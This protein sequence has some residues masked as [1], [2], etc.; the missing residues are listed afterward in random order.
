MK[1]YVLIEEDFDIY[2]Y[3]S[4]SKK[5]SPVLKVDKDILFFNNKE[6]ELNGIPIEEWLPV[7]YEKLKH[8]IAGKGKD[9]SNEEVITYLYVY[10][11]KMI[12]KEVFLDENEDYIINYKIDEQ[13]Y[14]KD[15]TQLNLLLN[16]LEKIFH[17]IEPDRSNEKTFSIF[18][19]DLII[20]S[21]TEVETHWK[22]L[23]KLNGY[24]KDNLTTKDYSK[25]MEFINFNFH[26]KLENYP[27]YDEVIPFLNWNIENPTKSLEWYNVYN[28][29]KHDRT[30]SLNNATLYNAIN[31][32]GAVFILVNIRYSNLSTLLNK[33]ELKNEIKTVFKISKSVKVSKWKLYSPYKTLM[34]TKYVKY[35][36]K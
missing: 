12:L 15:I 10:N 26:L 36:E 7:N 21:S 9:G 32:V 27:T 13:T 6:F 17:Y 28:I 11:E 30:N 33:I 35:F 31:S 18:L 34:K 16:D 23:M 8:T 24:K 1:K 22:E 19:R 2:S 5:I 20:K 4:S 3:S 14:K 29:L 25:L